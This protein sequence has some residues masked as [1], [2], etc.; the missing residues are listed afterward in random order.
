MNIDGWT[1]IH[2]R[3]ETCS[4]LRLQVVV[5]QPTQSV[6]MSETLIGDGQNPYRKRSK[7]SLET[8]QILT[9]NDRILIGIGAY[10]YWIS[11]QSLLD[12]DPMLTGN[13]AFP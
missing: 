13:E 10:P 3:R 8:D 1:S 11:I 2:N 7:S 5:M 9:G 4:S 12:L 6:R